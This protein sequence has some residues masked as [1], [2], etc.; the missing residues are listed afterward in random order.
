[1]WFPVLRMKW[2]PALPSP[3]KKKKKKWTFHSLQNTFTRIIALS[4]PSKSHEVGMVPSPPDSMQ[5]RKR[6]LA[7]QVPSFP[8]LFLWRQS[9]PF[10]GQTGHI[11]PMWPQDPASPPLLRP[12]E[13]SLV[14][15]SVVVTL[16]SAAVL[17]PVWGMPTVFCSIYIL[18]SM[19]PVQ[20]PD[21]FE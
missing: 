20:K 5:T 8:S 19:V 18:C 2:A 14:L 6:R 7:A 17:A 10:W 16:I 13:K 1:M 9:W 11:G 12:I 3:V 15:W 4:Q 21:I